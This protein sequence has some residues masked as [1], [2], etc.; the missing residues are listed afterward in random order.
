MAVGRSPNVFES[1]A[2]FADSVGAQRTSISVSDDGRP[3]DASRSRSIVSYAARAA[4]SPIDSAR[5]DFTRPRSGRRAKTSRRC[6]GGG[7]VENKAPSIVSR[8]MR[9]VALLTDFGTRDPYVAAMKGVIT[10][11]CE[12]HIVDLTHDIAPFDIWEGAFF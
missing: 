8:S 1:E 4:S 9:T 7:M 11:R 5:R 6:A 2:P 10:S 3:I 12:A